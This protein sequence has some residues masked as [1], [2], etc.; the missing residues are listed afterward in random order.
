MA[1]GA[2]RRSCGL[3]NGTVGDNEGTRRTEKEMDE[4]GQRD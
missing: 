3:S 1:A 4:E 2:W